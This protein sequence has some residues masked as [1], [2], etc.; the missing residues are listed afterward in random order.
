MK[1]Q[2]FFTIAF[3]VCATTVGA[4]ILPNIYV[5]SNVVRASTG[6]TADLT[7]TKTQDT[8]FG[9]TFPNL[10]FAATFDN[11][12]QL[13]VKVT[14][15]TAD[16]YEI[17]VTNTQT[18][19]Q[20]NLENALYSFTLNESPF[21][22]EVTRKS[23]GE[24]IYTTD[25]SKIT[26][27]E[28]FYFADQLIQLPTSMPSNF[29]IYGL[30]E[31]VHQFQLYRQNDYYVTFALDN[32]YPY[33]T[34]HA[35]G[36]NMYGEHPFMLVSSEQ[37]QGGVEYHGVFFANTNAQDAHITPDNFTW[38]S[39]GGI[40]ELYFFMGNEPNDVISQYQNLIGKPML[41]P[42]WGL[43]WSQ[44]RYGYTGLAQ[45]KGVLENYIANNVPLDAL[46]TDI[47]Y[48]DQYRDFTLDPVNWG[49]QSV[50][51]DFIDQLKGGGRYFVPILDAG[52]AKEDYFGY[53]QGTEMDIWIKRY[54]GNDDP[55]VGKVWP[56]FATFVDWYHP[57]ATDY[58]VDMLTITDETV[59][60]SGIWLDMNEVSNFCNGQC[61]G[62]YPE[63]GP[64][65][66][67]P[68][69]PGLRPLDVKN[70]AMTAAHY[71]GP[72]NIEYNLHGTYGTME[73]IATY[74]Y[75]IR[76]R[77]ERPMII[78]RSTYPGHG[79]Y[80]GHW[81]G[82]NAST[83]ADLAFSIPGIIDFQMFGIPLVG[84]EV[85]GFI[86]NTTAELCARWMELGSLYPFARN[87]TDKG[88]IPQD[89]YS[90]GPQ[91]LAASQKY[92]RIRYS[93]ILYM[94]TLFY[95]AS[96]NGSTVWRHMMF[97]FPQDV[98]TLTLDQQFLL[99]DAILVTPALNEGQTQV[100]AY[101]PDAIFYDF[102]TYELV[103][104][105]AQDVTVDAPLTEM[106]MFIRGGYALVMQDASTAL[107]MNDLI[108]QPLNLVFAL[109]SNGEAS[110]S[111]YFDDGISLNSLEDNLNATLDISYSNDVVKSTMTINNPDFVISKFNGFGDVTLIG[112]TDA[113][114]SAVLT[115]GGKTYNLTSAN[116]KT[117]SN[118]VTFTGLP[119]DAI[120]SGNFTLNINQS[121]S[122]VDL[123]QEF[124]P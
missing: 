56:G 9:P 107:C 22:F 79:K 1:T 47:G 46:W 101:F 28:Y 100:T 21:Y 6:V 122:N 14:N 91:V 98:K 92:L 65:M 74:E 62:V 54:K 80:A 10:K 64:T 59:G 97:E 41:I 87:H 49:P 117:T 20:S 108:S 30:G 102:E 71:G 85:C 39:V 69:T 120:M 26:S 106:P 51:L 103:S 114:K 99:G 13:H 4:E 123:G 34:G 81:L 89:P 121:D 57:N 27:Q 48:M 23:N 63:I 32:P 35:P 96:T 109:D 94:Y 72:L 8:R 82:D 68:Y 112:Y 11:T 50:F 2:A 37:P 88:T 44:S 119:A 90:L 18:I 75:F 45:F 111:Y 52:V 73:S 43:G 15:P 31:R 40:V 86:G 58:W 66:S 124:L 83:W 24:V 95:Q 110:Y 38:H 16:R 5:A 115:A 17:P 36:D 53:N 84:A 25:A 12:Y 19:D 70:I 33:A 113:V 3:L 78:S 77:K 61:G 116:I 105:K 55:F 67:T 118:S 93:I 76:V 60:F 7:L 42:L 104:D 29:Q